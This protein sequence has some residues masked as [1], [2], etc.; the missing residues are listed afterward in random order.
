MGLRGSGHLLSEMVLRS[1]AGADCE[2]RAAGG[3]A[4]PTAARKLSGCF[5]TLARHSGLHGL[6]G[7]GLAIRSIALA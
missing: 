2:H 7:S 1:R 3:S 4:H 6:R 5:L